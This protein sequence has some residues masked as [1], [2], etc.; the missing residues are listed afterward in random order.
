[1]SE[2]EKLTPMGHCAPG[3]ERL[4][5]DGKV[6]GCPEQGI[7]PMSTSPNPIILGSHLLISR[8]RPILWRV[9]L[10]LHR[11]YTA[12]HISPG[13]TPLT[14]TAAHCLDIVEAHPRRHLTTTPRLTS[15][16]GPAKLANVSQMGSARGKLV[17]ARWD[18]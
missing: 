6:C 7:A 18:A 8:K 1:M 2:T 16:M 14:I 15:Y 13:Q 9:G 17:N 3:I 5:L 11:L 12:H 4:G 10:E